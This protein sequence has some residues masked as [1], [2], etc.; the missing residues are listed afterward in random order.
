MNNNLLSLSNRN[1]NKSYYVTRKVWRYQRG[2]N[3]S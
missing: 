1:Q 3:K 2:Y